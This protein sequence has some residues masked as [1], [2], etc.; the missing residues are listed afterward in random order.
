MKIKSIKP[1]DYN[2]DVYNLRIKSE[3][4]KNHNYFSN[5]LNVS[6]CHKAKSASIK[7]ILE[8]CENAT[9]KFGLSGTIPKPG[10]LDRLTLMAYTGPIIQ[11]IRADYLIEKG[12]ITPCE[13]YVI[14]MDYAKPEVKEGFKT[15]FQRTEEDRKRLLNLEQQYA[16]QSPERLE[17]IT[18]TIL[19]NKKNALVLF[20]RIEYGNKIYENIRKM[21]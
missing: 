20:Y 10:T 13:V 12:H 21:I 9:R 2:N 16:I 17:F 3:D 15:L 6:N 18:D 14:E 11:S 5:R 1:I 4:G 19:K 7:T 8:K